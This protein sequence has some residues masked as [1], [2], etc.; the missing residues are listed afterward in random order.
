MSRLT[1]KQFTCTQIQ[2]SLS[3]DDALLCLEFI[4]E[5]FRSVQFIIQNVEIRINWESIGKFCE[6]IQHHIASSYSFVDQNICAIRNISSSAYLRWTNGII[7]EFIPF[8]IYFY[9]CEIMTSIQVTEMVDNSHQ[10][11]INSSSLRMRLLY[12]DILIELYFP[13][14]LLVAVVSLDES[15]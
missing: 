11:I 6:L 1:L 13:C 2:W 10:R 9:I 3:A 14:V 15:G 4:E 5:A 7:I 8:I 12:R